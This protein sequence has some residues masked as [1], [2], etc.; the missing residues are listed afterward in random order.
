MHLI[1]HLTKLR[2]L[3]YFLQTGERRHSGVR[4][5]DGLPSSSAAYSR[6][7]DVLLNPEVLS[8]TLYEY[9]AAE[10]FER[11]PREVRR[12]LATIAALPPLES[13]ELSAFLS[14]PDAADRIVATGPQLHHR[15]VCSRGHSVGEG[16]SADDAPWT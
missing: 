13:S 6:L 15:I 9:F 14:L 12:G 1:S 7:F 2:L 16:R 4:R 5:A 10:L 11:A 8:A 3:N